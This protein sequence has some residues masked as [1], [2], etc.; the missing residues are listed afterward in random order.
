MITTTKKINKILSEYKQGLPIKR[1]DKIFYRGIEGTL[2]SNVIF[3]LTHD[4]LIEYAKCSNDIF[5]F[6]E[7]YCNIKL[8]EYQIEWISNFINNRFTI[9]CTSRQTGYS[10][11]ISKVYLHYLIFNV[12]KKIILI[13]NKG[14]TGKEFISKVYDTYLKLPFFIKPGI[15]THNT[16]S[17]KFSNNCNISCATGKWY[18]LEKTDVLS[19]LDFSHIPPGILNY[20]SDFL[21]MTENS[22]SRISIQSQPNGLNKF[23]EL[24]VNSERKEKDPKKNIYKTIRTYWWE[25][26]GRDEEW[27]RE[28]I[29]DIGGQE[30]FA[31][32]YDMQFFT[33]KK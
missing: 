15:V 28:T 26:E 22:N 16:K 14:D 2:N 21:K 33:Y 1:T 9:F 11:I 17:I 18:N 4:E 8:R 29:S 30:A 24:L 20:D 25:V 27:K 19:Y 23:Y 12:D 10:Q 31:Q 7:K 5:Y 13:S 3:A 32:E 6:I